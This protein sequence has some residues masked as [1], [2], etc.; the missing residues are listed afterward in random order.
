MLP[1]RYAHRVTHGTCCA[2]RARMFGKA[3][4][5][6]TWRC[7]RK[8]AR[9]SCSRGRRWRFSVDCDSGVTAGCVRV[10][11]QARGGYIAD[12]A[13]RPIVMTLRHR[14]G[15]TRSALQTPG[16][17]GA[18]EA[19]LPARRCRCRSRL[20]R[21]PTCRAPSRRERQ[22]LLLQICSCPRRR[23]TLGR[24]SAGPALAIHRMS[25]AHPSGVSG[26]GPRALIRCGLQ[27]RQCN[28]P[29]R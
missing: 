7:G 5:F 15:S 16:R 8:M 4:R 24:V 18:R 6:R 20:A 13:L 12:S 1:R 19:G 21:D 23:Q 3:T 27:M 14:V 17:P 9:S 22:L 26:S 2:A 10:V 28:D 11:G 29:S 25:A